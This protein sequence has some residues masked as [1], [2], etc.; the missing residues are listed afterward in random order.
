MKKKNIKGNIYYLN[1]RF[2][3]ADLNIEYYTTDSQ[4][5][6]V[7]WTREDLE[8][9]GFFCGTN[10]AVRLSAI[11]HYIF[12]P[13]PWKDTYKDQSLRLYF[14]DEKYNKDLETLKNPPKD[15]LV[16]LYNYNII[17]FGWDCFDLPK[18]LQSVNEELA[19]EMALYI[20]LNK[21]ERKY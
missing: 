4:N 19:D 16:D 21:D 13:C 1:Y 5:R 12:K 11:K 2:I 3:D 20:E 9:N 17:F 18:A 8:K 7:P 6:R 10:R 14:S 15:R